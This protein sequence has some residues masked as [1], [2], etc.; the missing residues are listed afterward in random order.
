MYY[1]YTKIFFA[2]K[3]ILLNPFSNLFAKR[4]S[5]QLIQI[6]R[7]KFYYLFYYPNFG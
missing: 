1:L 6:Y 3:T 7:G 4:S 2:L 5:G